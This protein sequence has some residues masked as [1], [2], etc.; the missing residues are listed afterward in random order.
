MKR[1]IITPGKTASCYFRSSVQLPNRK[2]LLQITECCN[3]NCAH[4]FI[5]AK[6]YGRSISVENI[7]KVIIPR[8]KQCRVTRITLTGGEP[9]LHPNII[10]I[11]SLFKNE[12]ISIGIC[13]NGTAISQNEIE[14]L[15]KIGNVH[16]NVSLDGFS[17]TSHGKFRGDEK[18]FAK[19]IETIRQ[20]GQMY[21]LQGLLVTPNN[22]AGVEEYIKLCEFAKANNATYVLMNPLS[23][24]GRGVRSK[25]I[26]GSPNQTMA[27]IRKLTENFNRQI[28]I[29]YV[30]FP[31]EQALPLNTC[32]AGN[33]FYVFANGQLAVCAYLIFAASTPQSQYSPEEFIIGNI[34]E[35]ADI[36]DKLNNYKFHRKYHL[37][38]NSTCKNCSLNPNCGKG[39]PAAIIASGNKI[40]SVDQEICP[41]ISP[42]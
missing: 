20:L 27:E 10:E 37:G 17:P 35:D 30:R 38:N 16:V 12:G 42:R 7:A 36:A 40:E 11:V 24:M 3:L 8:L 19:T 13:T 41:I 29:H 32:E 34:F 1:S 28:Q 9:F 23:S 15:G 4:C 2:A 6:K 18:S 21:L 31:N 22:L 33:I 26:L 14:E 39:C 25:E 5:S